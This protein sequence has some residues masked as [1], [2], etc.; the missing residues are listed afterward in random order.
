MQIA[1]LK[2]YP[3]RFKFSFTLFDSL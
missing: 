2:L 1:A 3:H